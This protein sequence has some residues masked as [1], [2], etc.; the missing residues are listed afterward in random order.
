MCSEANW[1]ETLILL[2]ELRAMGFFSVWGLQGRESSEVPREVCVFMPR[3]KGCQETPASS[4]LPYIQCR[5]D[6]QT[7]PSQSL[8]PPSILGPFHK[9]GGPSLK[10]CWHFM[11]WPCLELPLVSHFLIC[12]PR[13][14]HV[15]QSCG[16]S[17]PL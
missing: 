1:I 3:A 14:L 2:Q 17:S 11:A 16:I 13:S 4:A 12:N 9:E 15:H 6:G 8:V 7:H 5:Y 10:S